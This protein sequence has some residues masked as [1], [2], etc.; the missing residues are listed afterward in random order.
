MK[1][2]DF[3]SGFSLVE[4]VVAV[5]IFAVAIVGVI[6]LFGPTTKNVA[7]VADA[8]SSTRAVGAIQ[9]SLKATASTSAGFGYI[10]KA[11][12]RNPAVTYYANRVGDRVDT[13][14]TNGDR[15]QVVTNNS[16]AFFQYT[17]S[18]FPAGSPLA[19]TAT[20][21]AASGY[22]AFTI[23]IK[24]PAYLPTADG[25]TGTAVAAS[26]QNTLIVPAAV[27]R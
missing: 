12:D 22:L 6:G 9:A 20:L 8:D 27:T 21:D 14:T 10:I 4:V 26:Q 17:I 11:L 24:W 19:S 15:S 16:E 13:I 3:R 18:R 2:T 25:I 7:A 5:G 23:T 1:K